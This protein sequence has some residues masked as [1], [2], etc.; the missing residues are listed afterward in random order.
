[1][2]WNDYLTLAERLKDEEDDASRRSAIS[3]AYY[4]AYNVANDWYK[5]DSKRR[6]IGLAQDAQGHH[7][8]LWE[9]IKTFGGTGS[10]IAKHGNM[11]RI[12]RNKCDYDKNISSINLN[13]APSRAIKIAS[14]IID[15]VKLLK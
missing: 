4:A 11:L 7:K 9:S 2:N 13:V 14:K 12:D 5:S 8:A 15:D 6:Q 3:R 1:L 10:L